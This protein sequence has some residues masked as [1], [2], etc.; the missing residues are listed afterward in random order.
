MLGI[1]QKQQGDQLSPGRAVGGVAEKVGKG[2][3][4]R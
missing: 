3:R 1:F 2:D 4:L